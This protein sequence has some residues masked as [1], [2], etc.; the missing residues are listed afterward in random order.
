MCHGLECAYEVWIPANKKVYNIIHLLVKAINE[1]NDNCF[2][3]KQLPLLYDKITA[4]KIDVNLTVNQT[5]IRSG[6]EL[7]LI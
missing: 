2:N 4:E 3:S 6:T 5:G 1:L 7:I